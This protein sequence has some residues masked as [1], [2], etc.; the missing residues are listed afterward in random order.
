MIRRDYILKSIEEFARALR[1][2]LEYSK[3]GQWHEAAQTAG[4][5]FQ[6]LIGLD[7]A[8]ALQLSET[9]LLARLIQ[10]GATDPVGVKAM[11]LAALLKATGELFTA[12]ERVEEARISYLKGLHIL[13]E[14][15]GFEE[16][17]ERPDFVPAVEAFLLALGDAPLPISTNAILMRHYEQTVQF[18]KAE[19][20]LFALLD[21]EPSSMELL[22]FGIG[23][24]RRLLAASDDAL[25][26]GNLPRQEVLAGLR[27]LETRKSSRTEALANS[28]Q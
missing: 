18:G 7:A 10:H 19:D 12:Q 21:T 16:T 3:S 4:D 22:E 13:L 1:K 14:T 24:Y 15:H 23:F 5:Q 20:V 6:Q 9:E 26:L 2:L 27:E 11:M 8:A 17:A 28:P 25:A